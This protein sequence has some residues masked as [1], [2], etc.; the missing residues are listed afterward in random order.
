MALLQVEDDAFFD[1][2]TPLKLGALPEL[3]DGVVVYGFPDG[4][5]GLS[6]TEGIVSRIEITEYVHSR[7]Q[8][9]ISKIS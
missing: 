6:V 7:L 2:T 4:G 9:L 1:N 5:D 8:F 3:L